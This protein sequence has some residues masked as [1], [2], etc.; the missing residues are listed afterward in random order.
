MHVSDKQTWRPWPALASAALLGLSLLVGLHHGPRIVSR[1]LLLYLSWWL[2]VA[3]CLMA[4][5]RSASGAQE[6]PAPRRLAGVCNLLFWLLVAYLCS[7]A[8]ASTW[9]YFIGWQPEGPLFYRYGL[10]LFVLISAWLAVPL[11]RSTERQRE[12]ALG[13][14]ALASMAGCAFA[15]LA[16]TGG[17]ALYRDDHPSFLYRLVEFGRTFPRLIWY[18]PWING[19]TE[20]HTVGGI[21][22]LGILFWPLWRSVAPHTVYTPIVAL[23]FIVALPMACY[24]AV[25]MVGGGRSGAWVGALLGLGVSQYYFMWLLK[26]GTL[27]ALIGSACFPLVVASLYRII[28]RSRTGTG[29]GIVLVIAA[30][31][32]L[33]WPP[34][35]VLA[36]SLAA[37]LL[38]SLRQTRPRTWIYLG[39]LG[40]LL[41]L[42]LTYPLLITIQHG[43]TTT[44]YVMQEDIH[45]G[46]VA[47]NVVSRFGPGFERLM[48]NVR[49][50][51]P[52]IVW[53]CLAPL[54]VPTRPGFRRWFLLLL[55]PLTVVSA[56]G[57]G[58]LPHLDLYRLAIP[59]LLV[60]A[61][62]AALAV[63][64]VLAVRSRWFVPARAGL[65]A[66]LILCSWNAVRV[67]ANQGP[68]HY[69][70]LD[71]RL[72]YLRGWIRDY[73]THDGRILFAG[74]SGHEYGGGH[75]AYLPILFDREI[76]ASDYY[77]FPPSLVDYEMPPLRFLGGHESYWQYLEWYNVSHIV[78]FHDHQKMYLRS[79]PEAYEELA[80]V[81]R[82]TF[83]RVIRE[84]T[85]FLRGAG[86][87]EAEFNRL[88]V[89]LTGDTDEAVLCYNYSDGLMAAPPVELFPHE[90]A[91][92]VRLIGIRPHG[93]KEFEI[94]YDRWW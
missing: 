46:D 8:T 79:H 27:G 16:G 59:A 80:T 29:Q 39:L 3:F 77:H 35:A 50:A 58:W 61:I 60:A 30:L 42:L 10:P 49:A 18:T 74:P 22:S 67:Y 1:G 94:R 70:A 84:P 36:L 45:G 92:G 68:M 20:H 11:L 53:M 9:F 19:G 75:V 43:E 37:P 4:C 55:A 56:W 31:F 17:A 54:L 2:P 78:T 72:D 76:L 81:H 32:L 33:L 87:V 47:A 25:R 15:L 52:I 12:I 21:A 89:T 6:D 85:F 13:L 73:T 5:L 41:A 71:E 64:A 86:R 40:F 34:G 28:W 88:Q 65:A 66:L 91:E 51:N 82:R 7:R 26:I 57:G 90:V 63:E 44:R 48:G 69:S 62:P 38:A 14:L 93:A 24:T 83:Y 23:L